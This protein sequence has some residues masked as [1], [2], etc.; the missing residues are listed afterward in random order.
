MACG[1]RYSWVMNPLRPSKPTSA[2]LRQWLF[3]PGSLTERLRQH[4]HVTVKIL[5]QGSQCLWSDEQH[6]LGQSNAHTREVF[7]LLNGRPVVWARSATLH[8]AIQGPWKAMTNLG[9]RPLA[10]LLFQD[11]AVLRSPLQAHALAR[12]GEVERQMRDAWA[13]FHAS[14]TENPMPRWGRSS[15]F[16]RRGQPLRVFEAFAP[17][18]QTLSAG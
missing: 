18:V 10:E 4:G 16:W 13:Q 11:R 8:T 2:S 9:T 17:W 14:T 15:V 5:H 1:L 7:L 3:A 6:D 12:H